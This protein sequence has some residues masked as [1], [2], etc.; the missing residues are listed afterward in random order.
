MALWDMLALPGV[1]FV[2]LLFHSAKCCSTKTASL[3]RCYIIIAI[4]QRVLVYSRPKT[5][6]KILDKWI[7]ETFFKNAFIILGNGWNPQDWSPAASFVTLSK[8]KTIPTPSRNMNENIIFG[9][10]GLRGVCLFHFI[11]PYFYQAMNWRPPSFFVS[12]SNTIIIWF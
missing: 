8:C 3:D 9:N 4:C 2:T 12:L 7:Y 10:Q 6:I 1:L 11:L 5:K